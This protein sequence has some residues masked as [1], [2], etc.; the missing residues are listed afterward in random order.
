MKSVIRFLGLDESLFHVEVKVS[1]NSKV[2]VIEVNPRLGGGTIRQN[3]I[4]LTN[5]D[6]LDILVDI[7]CG[8]SPDVCFE[9]L[10]NVVFGCGVLAQKTG[11]IRGI[12]GL[13]EVRAHAQV[14]HVDVIHD[15]GD[16]VEGSFGE[17]YPVVVN[18]TC[19]SQEEAIALRDE[20]I[21][22]INV[23]ID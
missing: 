16:T 11:T 10:V 18:G 17:V 22:T 21:S 20:I 19:H 2:E 4:N 6:L 14:T 23:E 1:D 3:I 13:D 7:H 5:V 12:S 9:R 8:V 15:I